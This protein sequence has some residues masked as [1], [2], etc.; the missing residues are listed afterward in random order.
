MQ[1][2]A[3][4]NPLWHRLRWPGGNKDIIFEAYPTPEDIGNILQIDNFFTFGSGPSNDHFFG[5]LENI[6]NLM[7]N[8]SGGLNPHYVQG[9]PPMNRDE[10]QAGDMVNAG[11]TAFAPIFW[12]H[13][14]NVDRLWAEWQQQH[15][16]VGPDDPTAILPPWQMTVQQTYSIHNLGYE[17]MK[18]SHLFPTDNSLPI[19]RFRSV[20]AG[21]HPQVLANHRRAEVRLHKVQYVTR[22]GFHVRVFLN[23]PQAD[24]TTPTR[25]NDHYVG[26]RNMFTGLCIGGPGHCAVPSEKRRK[27]DQRPRPHKTP[28]NF[29]L[30]ATATVQKLVA[31][32]ARDLQV[33][34]VVLNTDGTVASDALVLDAVSLNFLD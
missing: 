4:I 34:L 29:R 28:G 10:P 31:S 26:Q 16:N 22:P 23:Q 1:V 12:G 18:S 32:D 20:D 6:H 14:S 8:F 13:H 3:G 11:V 5:A 2:L 30:D 7:H 33:H 21:V 9:T 17:Y 15:P 19:Q 27:F 24:A 25:G